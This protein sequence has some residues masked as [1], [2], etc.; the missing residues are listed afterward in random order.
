MSGYTPGPWAIV[1]HEIHGP[2]D[3][4][5]IAARIPEWGLLA[6]KPNPGPANARL[7]AAAPDLLEVTQW[8][9][10]KWKNGHHMPPDLL[11]KARE[12]IV[13]ATS[14]PT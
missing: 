8:V 7:I 3:S 6:D 14:T 10:G 4:G 1:G 11:L 2:Q 9:I 12:A 5:V 13:K